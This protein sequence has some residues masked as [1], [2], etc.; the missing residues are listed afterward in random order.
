M[1]RIEKRWLFISFIFLFL[2]IISPFTSANNH[3]MVNYNEFSQYDPLQQEQYIDTYFTQLTSEVAW[4]EGDTEF[5]D[6]YFKEQGASAINTHKEVFEHFMEQKGVVITLNGEIVDYKA[7]GTLVAQ[8]NTQVN[9]TDWVGVYDFEVDT[10]GNLQLISKGVK[11]SIQGTVQRNDMGEMIVTKGSIGGKQID[12]GILTIDGSV[13]KGKAFGFGDTVF[14]GEEQRKSGVMVFNDNEQQFKYV[15]ARADFSYDARDNSLTILNPENRP[16]L[17]LSKVGKDITIKSKSNAF[18]YFVDDGIV[19]KNSQIK[20]EN[21]KVTQIKTP[22]SVD[23]HDR[24]GGVLVE[25]LIHFLNSGTTL[26]LCYD[27]SCP[28]QGNYVHYQADGFEVSGKG[29]ETKLDRAVLSGIK[30]NVLGKEWVGSRYELIKGDDYPPIQRKFLAENYFEGR[31]LEGN[32]DYYDYFTVRPNGG[33]V[34][35]TNIN[36]KVGLSVAGPAVINNGYWSIEYDG[37]KVLKREA[38]NPRTHSRSQS[39]F[40]SD[41]DGRDVVPMTVSFSNNDNSQSGYSFIDYNG[42]PDIFVYPGRYTGVTANGADPENEEEFS[43]LFK[44]NLNLLEGQPLD[45]SEG[46]PLEEIPDTNE[47]VCVDVAICSIKQTTGYDILE[48]MAVVGKGKSWGSVDLRSNWALYEYFQASPHFETR[49]FDGKDFYG[50]DE[51]LR[52]SWKDG[53]KVDINKITFTDQKAPPVDWEKDYGLRKD[54]INFVMFEAH[55][56]Q[57]DT[58]TD[59]YQKIGGHPQDHLV[60]VYWGEYENKYTHQK[61]EGWISVQAPGGC[62]ASGV[63]EIPLNDWIATRRCESSIMTAMRGCIGYMGVNQ[64]IQPKLGQLKQAAKRK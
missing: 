39:S 33:R 22:L 16:K 38:Y 26:N 52:G 36:N 57:R 53:Q 50:S 3:A 20:V 29:F 56:I 19:L 34:A 1:K 62:R 40:I 58:S 32:A 60:P 54:R 18:V 41:T 21:G 48:D 35:Y 49:Q 6:Q 25:G 30:N 63:C 15:S 37:S 12:G 31:G 13:I 28:K 64:V 42:R 4:S 27:G 17:F 14:A 11:H 2:V 55:D 8:D 46:K 45:F 24:G 44:Y 23:P 7:D 10:D 47:F 5:V 59:Q 61:N 9:P 51:S 43:N